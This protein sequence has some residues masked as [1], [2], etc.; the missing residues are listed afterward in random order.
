MESCERVE[1]ISELLDLDEFEV[2]AVE[3]D[4]LARIRRLTVIPRIGV[5]LCPHCGKATGQAH[6]CRDRRVLDLPLGGWRTELIV[7]LRQYS[8]ET[9]NRYFTPHYAA[10]AEGSH[11]TERLLERMAELIKHGDIVNAAKFFG[12]AEKTAEGWYYE[13][14]ER[15]G[16]GKRKGLNPIRSLGIDELS[17]KKNIVNSAVS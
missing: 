4:R 13:Y 8:C 14:L 12:I 17:L 10:L 6:E 9:C 16:A 5:G 3:S 11:A 7:R 15:N 2:V 1:C